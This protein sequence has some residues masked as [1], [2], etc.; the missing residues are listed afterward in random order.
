MRL[1]MA[2][3]YNKKVFPYFKKHDSGTSYSCTGINTGEHVNSLA[4][5]MHANKTTVSA[6]KRS[7]HGVLVVYLDVN[8]AI[9][10]TKRRV[11]G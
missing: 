3:Y 10:E 7:R 4:R 8:L 5:T 6:L 11:W 1:I 2:T 9:N